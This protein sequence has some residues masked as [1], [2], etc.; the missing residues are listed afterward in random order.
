MP[1][2]KYQKWYNNLIQFRKNNIP[3]GY[4]ENH[5]I[6][7]K[8]LGGNNKKQNLVYLTGREHWVAHLL[9]HKIYKKPSTAHAC[10]MMAVKCEKRGIPYIKNSRM[11][12]SIRI[13]CAQY[14]SKNGK[15]RLGNKNG[16]WETMWIANTNLQKNKKIRKNEKIPKGWSKGRIL[17][18]NDKNKIMRFKNKDKIYKIKCKNCEKS[19]ESKNRKIKFCSKKCS[20]QFNFK[21]PTYIFIQKGENSKKIKRENL[22]AYRKIGWLMV[23]SEGIEPT[24]FLPPV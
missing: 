16:A 18:W 5:H 15:E 23:T 3:R 22:S 12:E 13:E 8:C 7:P 2:D 17:N 4:K 10:S 20:C 6:L 9:L 14:S 21:N 1:I 19:I 24:D 11:Y